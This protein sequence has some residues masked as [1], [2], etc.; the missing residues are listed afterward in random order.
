MYMAVV[1]QSQYSFIN[2][3]HLL[4]HTPASHLPSFRAPLTFPLLLPSSVPA[5]QRMQR[6]IVGFKLAVRV[7]QQAPEVA[8]Q[9]RLSA[10]ERPQEETPGV[11]VIGV[12]VVPDERRA[13][14]DR[15]HLRQAVCR[16]L[17]RDDL[18]ACGTKTGGEDFEIQANLRETTSW[19]YFCFPNSVSYSE[20]LSD[21]WEDPVHYKKVADLKK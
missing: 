16:Q 14:Q 1:W 13:L 5:P 8:L 18:T 21:S 12:Q 17:P 10:L 4:S 3:G 2:L 20:N 9:L 19:K 6:D 11:I 7:E 15:L